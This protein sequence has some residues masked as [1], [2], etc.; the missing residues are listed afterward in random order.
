M[1]ILLDDSAIIEPRAIRET[2]YE[3]NFWKFVNIA[4]SPE[5]F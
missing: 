4:H 5:I 1:I 2:S 3:Y